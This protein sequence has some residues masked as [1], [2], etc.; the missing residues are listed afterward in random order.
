[1]P[2]ER[3]S[4]TDVL[5]DGTDKLNS[6]ID[7]AN[8]AEVDSLTAINTANNATETASEANNKADFTQTQ[9][10]QVTGAST[11]D[12]AVEQMKVDDTGFAHPS[13]DARLRS[14]HQKLTS[15]LAE[16]ATT[17]KAFDAVGDG[18]TDDTQAFYNMVQYCNGFERVHINLGRNT[19]KVNKPVNDAKFPTTAGFILTSKSVKV[20]GDNAKVLLPDGSNFEVFWILGDA[21]SYTSETDYM[22]TTHYHALNDYAEFNGVN[23]DFGTNSGGTGVEKAVKFRYVKNAKFNG[24]VYGSNGNG[25]NF[26]QCNN[27]EFDG[28]VERHSQYGVF[29]YMCRAGKISGLIDGDGIGNRAYIIKHGYNGE[30]FSD[31]K[32]T[33]ITIKG[34]KDYG[35]NSGDT[36][37]SGSAVNVTNHEKVRGVE[38]S[39]AKIYIPS[40]G[41]ATTALRLGQYTNGWKIHDIDFIA[42]DDLP[43]AGN[44]MDVFGTLA[45]SA[46]G[47]SGDRIGNHDIRNIR[48]WNI[49]ATGGA[50]M[51]VRSLATIRGIKFINCKGSCL[52]YP[53]TAYSDGSKTAP[54][55]DIDDLE[56]INCTVVDD[57]RDSLI[58]SDGL[59]VSI[60]S[61]KFINTIMAAPN[62]YLI[63]PKG[64]TK[65]EVNRL[66]VDGLSGNVTYAVFLNGLPNQILN[67]NEIRAKNM[68]V[69]AS[70][71]QLI[72]SD[73]KEVNLSNV[74]ADFTGNTSTNR[75]ILYG[76]ANTTKVK[77]Q[78]G[79]NVVNE[80]AFF[81]L[82]ADIAALGINS[83]KRTFYRNSVPIAGTYQNGDRIINSEPYQGQPKGWVCVTSGSP[84][85]WVS[86]GTL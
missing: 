3:I 61:V 82:T 15:E 14:D 45:D 79:H 73:S 8:K 76:T 19:Y 38:V 43:I 25:V 22:A 34:V 41:F 86:E 66:V 32:I 62:S 68:T 12:P 71:L 40:G 53:I 1:M 84:G 65:V 36:L 27:I 4:Y 72:R 46:Q 63:F 83:T 6:A 24:I 51:M 5:K 7:Q 33:N 52:Y 50:I 47:A 56:F 80:T 31:I 35:I 60:G 26:E 16:I 42:T 74:S 44:V 85:V 57:V 30:I 64:N 54:M 10:D 2:T 69:T 28:M 29:A 11:I 18:V 17:P 23:F 21:G 78:G 48:F 67:I 9:L 58:F 77:D 81:F 59:D 20:S 13:P 37:E 75:N 49:N 55:M 70:S 39:H